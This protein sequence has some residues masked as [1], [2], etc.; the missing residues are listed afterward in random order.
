MGIYR[1]SPHASI[2]EETKM[3]RRILIIGGLAA[4]P[5]AASKAKRA[6]PE[7]EVVLF[8]QGE[9]ISYGIC[10]IP[11]L[12]SN[13]IIDPTRLIIYSPERLEKEKGVTAKTFHLV[14]EIH[15]SSKEIR[16][17]DLKGGITGTEHYD[18]L[19]IATGSTPKKLV[20]EGIES[21]NVFTVKG[22]D[23]AYAMKRY[24]DE[25]KPHRAVV[26]GGGFIGLEMA[27]A[28]VRRGIEV[29]MLHNAA[30][31][32]SKLEEEGRKIVNEEILK[33]IAGPCASELL[34]C[35]HTTEFGGKVIL[36]EIK[37]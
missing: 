23:E 14:E 31:P 2:Q 30:Q 9:Y 25:E 17:R 24:L 3:K 5:S 33:R 20:L 16:V 4:G 32:M 1:S 11:Y 35:K 37:I 22:L 29:T 12:I 21:R 15:A 10:E 19:I 6:D 27:D 28:F 36:K 34:N 13:E 18:K 26:I 7:A 8:E